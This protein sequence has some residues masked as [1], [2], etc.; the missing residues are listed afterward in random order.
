MNCPCPRFKKVKNG[1]FLTLEKD[2][3]TFVASG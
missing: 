1:Q 2:K 3:N